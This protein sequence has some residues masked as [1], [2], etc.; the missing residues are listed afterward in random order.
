MF[1]GLRFSHW[2]AEST[3]DG[4]VVLTIDR[5][6]AS[7]N[8]LNHAVLE[9]LAQILERLSFETPRGVVIRSGK[10]GGFIA[11]ADITSFTSVSTEQQALDL[12][13]TG[14]SV[15]NR[16]EA[17][18]FPTVAWY[19]WFLPGWRPGTGTGLPLSRHARRSRHPP[20]PARGASRHTSPAGAAAR[21]WYP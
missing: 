3:D 1:E 4:I 18:P 2:Q 9:E 13:N 12:L 19:P 7:V 8:A 11:G 10:P 6:D 21:A 20:R 5:A 15:F 16:L 14:Q 17:L